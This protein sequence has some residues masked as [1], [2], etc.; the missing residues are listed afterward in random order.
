M[1]KKQMFVI[2][3]NVLEYMVTYQLPKRYSD[4]R[5]KQ[6]A[7][8][9]QKRK[10]DIYILDLIWTEFL[11]VCLHKG[12]NFNNYEVWYRNRRSAVEKLYRDLV[13][14]D[15]NYIKVADKDNYSKLFEVAHNFAD[16]LHLDGFAEKLKKDQL[17]SLQGK[18]RRAMR[19]HNQSRANDLKYKIDKIKTDAKLFD[20][21]DGALAAYTYLVAEEYPEREVILV[22]GDK[23][24]QMTLEYCRKKDH[25]FT[26]HG[27]EYNWDV[28]TIDL[29]RVDSYC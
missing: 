14:N 24:L 3:T 28:K 2:D 27:Q 15:V 4:Y 6:C 12:I 9:Y 25:S 19:Q 1:S 29:P 5:T 18:R 8:I 16:S 17:N 21:I 7:K 11:G 26:V 20:G 10:N 23:S 22:T 13:V